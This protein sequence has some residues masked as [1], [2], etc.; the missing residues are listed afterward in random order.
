M[1]PCNRQHLLENII[2]LIAVMSSVPA[3]AS[4]F[5]SQFIDP[6]DGKLDT[7][8]WLATSTGFLPFWLLISRLVVCVVLSTCINGMPALAFQQ[9]EQNHQAAVETGVEFQPR[10]GEFHYEIHWEKT[11]VATGIV[12]ISK[13]E[14]YFRLTADQKTTKFIDRIY[15]VRYQGET[16]IKVQSLSPS[17]SFI[18]EEIKEDKKV[19]KIRYDARTGTAQVEEVRS[20]NNRT[21]EEKKTYELQDDKGIVDV[22]SAIFLTRSFDWSPG[23][24]HQFLIFVGDK[25]YQVT[26]ECIGKTT[27]TVDGY[28]VPVHVI[29][30]GIRRTNEENESPLH[31]KTRIYISADESRDIVKIKVQPGIGTVKLKLVKFQ[32]K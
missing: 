7:S 11:R 14:E 31:R 30:P 25:E 18:Q 17:E 6:R 27:L 8:Q 16:R 15:R 12:T 9:Q 20:Q 3:S 24:R 1:V 21:P 23:E 19:Q 10:L 2:V 13:E 5:F 22:F 4:S 29:R 26:L 28:V 32:E